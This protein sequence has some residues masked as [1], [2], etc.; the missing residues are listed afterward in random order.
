DR[1]AVAVASLSFRESE[2]SLVRLNAYSSGISRIN[3]SR[4]L[5]PSLVN[6]RGANRGIGNRVNQNEAAGCP[7]LMVG[8]KE[9]TFVGFELYGCDAVH[10]QLIGGRVRHS[11]YIHAVA[12]LGGL[13]FDVTPGMFHEILSIQFE[14]PGIEPHHHC[15]EA[16]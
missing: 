1:R 7:V 16:A 9:E 3:R 14:W 13:C 5:M 12:N 8:I 15:F 6:H 11:I 2:C 10:L 4:R